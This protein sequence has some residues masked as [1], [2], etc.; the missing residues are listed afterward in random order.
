MSMKTD[1]LGPHGD[2]LH[3]KAGG[4]INSVKTDVILSSFARPFDISMSIDSIR[5]V[6]RVFDLFQVSQ[7]SDRN[8]TAG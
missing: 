3:G 2:S 5:D 7:L 6:S 1:S 4:G 8:S